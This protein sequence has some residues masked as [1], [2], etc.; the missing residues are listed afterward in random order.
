MA[1]LTLEP[2]FGDGVN[3]QAAPRSCS[4]P[5]CQRSETMQQLI[6]D[7]MTREAHV[8]GPNA[9]LTEATA[10][11]QAEDVGALPVWQG[12]ELLGI[13]TD[14]DVAVRAVSQGHDPDEARVKDFM[15]RNVVT[16]REDQTL[17]H[18]AALMGHRQI[19]RLVVVDQNEQVKG[20]VTLDDLAVDAQDARLSGRTLETISVKS[21]QHHE[22][23]KRIL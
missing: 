23:F 2:Y 9:T 16:C 3:V 22:P 14:R 18:A 1:V 21:R 10:K 7:V 12:G 11:M 17:S 20:I 8:I 19:R 5:H 6:R 15:T 13:I 4:L